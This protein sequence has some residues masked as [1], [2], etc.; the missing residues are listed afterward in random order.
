MKLE[1]RSQAGKLLAAKLLKYK[2]ADPLILALPRGGVPV[3]SEVA[4]A[5]DADFDVIAVR[6]IGSPM[7]PELAIGAICENDKPL[8]NDSIMKQLRLTPESAKAT[9][10]FE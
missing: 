4:E 2:N 7:T 10:K 3:A 9:I 8:F 5:L 6:K 1:N